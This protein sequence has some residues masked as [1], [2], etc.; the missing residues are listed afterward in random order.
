[1]NEKLLAA[2]RL[3]VT[4]IILPERNRKDLQE[5]APELLEGLQLHFVIS[6]NEVLKLAMTK[7]PLVGARAK[8]PGH[9]GARIA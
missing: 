1:L 7:S 5:M 6:V 2:K 8:L 4:K 9:T 3:G